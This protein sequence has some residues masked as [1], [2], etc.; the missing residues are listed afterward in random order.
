MGTVEEPIETSVIATAS[1]ILIPSWLV[2]VKVLK[3]NDISTIGLVREFK[4]SL[5][6][7]NTCLEVLVFSYWFIHLL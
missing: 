3:A 1:D 2:K 6:V 5:Y 4:V 7:M